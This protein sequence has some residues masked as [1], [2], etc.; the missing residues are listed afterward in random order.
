MA[1]EVQARKESFVSADRKDALSKGT[2]E[3]NREQLRKAYAERAQVERQ[4]V[5]MER[6]RSIGPNDI[7]PAESVG[8]PVEPNPEP[9]KPSMWCQGSGVVETKSLPLPPPSEPKKAVRIVS[10]TPKAHLWSPE[11]MA[12]MNL[13]PKP[14]EK[15]CVSVED[16]EMATLFAA[17]TAMAK[18]EEASRR[19]V[20]RYLAERFG[21]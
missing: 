4:K 10:P 7:L 17:V 1:I 19:R 16:L 11:E 13:G 18:L 2:S 20:V 15:A 8:M 3:D 5:H 12:R 21:E 6:G 14:E 9:P